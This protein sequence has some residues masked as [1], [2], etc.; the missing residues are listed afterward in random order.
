MKRYTSIIFA[1]ICLMRSLTGCTAKYMPEDFIGKTSVEIIGEY[2]SFDC[3]LVPAS[4][5]GLYR[6][7][8]CG[9]TIAEPQKGFLG[10]SEEILL[11]I[12][13]DENGIATTCEEGNRPGG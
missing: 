3:V 1:V 8:K 13:F 9:Y 6:N 11:F 2:G 5:D 4:E 7:C 10:T 12:V